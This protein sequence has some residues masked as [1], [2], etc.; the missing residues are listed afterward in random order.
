M[1]WIRNG[2]TEILLCSLNSFLYLSFFLILSKPCEYFSFSFSSVNFVFVFVSFYYSFNH[3]FIAY[4][5]I[6]LF[7]FLPCHYNYLTLIW[8]HSHSIE[9]EMCLWLWQIKSNQS[10]AEAEAVIQTNADN[11][12]RRREK[13]YWEKKRERQQWIVAWMNKN[14]TNKNTID[15]QKNLKNTK[16]NFHKF[17]LLHSV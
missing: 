6:F 13:K 15:K 10:H 2:R 16:P 9:I 14:N 5:S 1:N 7:L 3:L 4:L 8:V 17:Y 11:E 12:I